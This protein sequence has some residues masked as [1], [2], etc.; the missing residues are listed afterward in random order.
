MSSQP[1]RGSKQILCST[2]IDILTLVL[3]FENEDDLRT[4]IKSTISFLEKE[5]NEFKKTKIKKDETTD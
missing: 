1:L 2:I 3:K 4:G 5:K